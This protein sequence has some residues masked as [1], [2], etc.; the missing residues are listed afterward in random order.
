M[1]HDGHGSLLHILKNRGLMSPSTHKVISTFMSKWNVDVFRA[2]I[3][4]HLVDES[5][6]ADILSEELKL[7]RLGRLRMLSVSDDVLMA[8]PY[9]VALECA[10]FPF[11]ISESGRLHIV[12]ADPSDT[13]T[14]QRIGSVTKRVVEVF[15]GE[16]SEIIS[17]VQMHYPLAMQLP[18]L[19]K[20]D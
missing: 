19:L 5:R 6:I 15:V 13:V 20:M 8:I 1:K 7:P 9:D 3:E 10:V 14:I 11:E 17:A 4:T 2:V 12:I 16:R 18:S